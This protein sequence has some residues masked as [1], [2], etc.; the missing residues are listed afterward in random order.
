M[1]YWQACVRYR[2]LEVLP[3]VP[4]SAEKGE[5]VYYGYPQNCRQGAMLLARKAMGSP[6][7][8]EAKVVERDLT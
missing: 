7:A 2:P 1:R 6:H 5:W 8:I 4:T 3:A